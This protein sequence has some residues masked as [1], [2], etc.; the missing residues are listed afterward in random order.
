MPSTAAT[1]VSSSERFATITI[2]WLLRAEAS[3]TFRLKFE[4]SS[5]QILALAAVACA[6]DL[7]A[8]Q[9]PRDLQLGSQ[10]QWLLNT[11]RTHAALQQLGRRRQLPTKADDQHYA[12]LRTAAD[13]SERLI[14]V[15]NFQPVPQTVEVDISGIATTGLVDL[16]TSS[17]RSPDNPLKVDLE[18]Y[19]YQLY[20]LQ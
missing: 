9:Y 3:T 12:F 15:M 11:K 8:G 16:R 5:K 18:A 6:G 19:G 1:P 20:K 4:E 7:V 13:N 2:E 10:A 17:I 14:V